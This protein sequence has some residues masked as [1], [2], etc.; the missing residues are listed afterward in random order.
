MSNSPT[1]PY[2]LRRRRREA[3]TQSGIM[4][5]MR[6]CGVTATAPTPTV[7]TRALTTVHVHVYAM[8]VCKHTHS[9]KLENFE[10]YVLWVCG[11]LQDSVCMQFFNQSIKLSKRGASV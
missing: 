8:C 6:P 10:K 4:S 11:L 5:G 9:T 7:C 3:I 2:A 1:S